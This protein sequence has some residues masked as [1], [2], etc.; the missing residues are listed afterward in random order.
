MDANGSIRLDRQPLLY[1]GGLPLFFLSQHPILLPLI[2]CSEL[3]HN[4]DFKEALAFS[5]REAWCPPVLRI[6]WLG[7]SWLQERPRCPDTC[8]L[9]DTRKTTT[10]HLQTRSIPQ[11]RPLG[12]CQSKGQGI[13]I[14]NFSKAQDLMRRLT[15]SRCCIRVDPG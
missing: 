10:S 5:V 7:Q 11:C 6:I 4:D 9:P 8:R 1:S 15:G 12:K 2:F 3:Q 13:T 14:M